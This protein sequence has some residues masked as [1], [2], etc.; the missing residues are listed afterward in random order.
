VLHPS[1][2]HV[3][4]RPNVLTG[5]PCIKSEPPSILDPF[6]ALAYSDIG[7]RTFLFVECRFIETDCQ[8]RT[9]FGSSRAT[10]ELTSDGPDTR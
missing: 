4:P 6:V 5:L 7:G 9:P 10:K 8:E 3:R 1:T 2:L